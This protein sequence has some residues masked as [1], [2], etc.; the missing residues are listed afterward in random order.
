[1]PTPTPEQITLMRTHPVREYLNEHHLTQ[2]QLARRSGVEIARLNEV[3]R[4]RK[5]YFS[6]ANAERLEKAT[7]GALKAD[8]LRKPWTG[9]PVK[10]KRR[11]K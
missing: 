11:S 8:E 6:E 5:T 10:T 9:A 1:M 3:L 4:G 2:A 7:E